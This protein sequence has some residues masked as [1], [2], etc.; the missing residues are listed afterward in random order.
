MADERLLNAGTADQ[1]R[2]ARGETGQAGPMSADLGSE[3]DPSVTTE[4]T[5]IRGNMDTRRPLDDADQA[6]VTDET[7]YPAPG[8]DTD[9]AQSKDT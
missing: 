5:T 6:T 8:L 3:E 2:E 9:E 1:L 7:A 4:A